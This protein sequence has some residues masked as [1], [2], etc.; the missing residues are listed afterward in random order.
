MRMKRSE[1]LAWPHKAITLLGMS[2]VGKTTLAY[3]LPADKW[4]HYS[5][6]YRIGTKYLAEP[7]LDNIKRQAMKVDF[8]RDLLRND[9]I[10]IASNVTVHNLQPVA[11]FLGKIGRTDLGGLPVDEFKKRQR[12]HREAEIGAM[13]DVAEFIIKA[14][15]IYGYDHFIN[16]AG[17]SLV[18]LDDEQTEKTLA[19]HT[20]ILYIKADDEMERELVRRAVSNPKPL[21]YNEKFLDQKLA[22]YLDEAEL[23]GPD[24]IVPDEFVRW[25]FPALVAHRRP[26]YEAMANRY[27]YTLNARLAEAVTNEADFLDLVAS[28]LD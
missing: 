26:K 23:E 14:Q 3:K 8:L 6:D 7:I 13:R 4:F 12:L 5:G 24:Q 28:V 20:L 27:G 19:E 15:E 10:Y 22:Q 11:T 1:F 18:E 16:D 25:I 21:Y 9:S 2:G 17:G